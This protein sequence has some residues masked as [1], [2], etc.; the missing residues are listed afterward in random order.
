MYI[1]TGSPAYCIEGYSLIPRLFERHGNKA[2][3]EDYSQTK[4]V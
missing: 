1:H 4:I 2:K 3:P